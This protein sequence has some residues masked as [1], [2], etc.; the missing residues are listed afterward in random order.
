MARRAPWKSA[1]G[2]P[3]QPSGGSTP[4]TTAR[5]GSSAARRARISRRA[6]GRAVV[7]DDDFE[8]RIV[9]RRD[10]SARRPR[11]RRPR[12]RRNHDETRG[13]A[14]ARGDLR[15][16]TDAPE[17]EDI[18]REGG[19]SRWPPAR[20]TRPERRGLVP[21][22]LRQRN[23]LP[24][25]RPVRRVRIVGEQ[26]LVRRPRIRRRA[27]RL[28]DLGEREEQGILGRGRR[29]GLDRAL[30]PFDGIRGLPLGSEQLGGID[31]GGRGGLGFALAR[32]LLEGL[33]RLGRL[34]GS[35][36]RED[37]A[38]SA[39]RARRPVRGRLAEELVRFGLALGCGRE[40]LRGGRLLGLQRRRRARPAPRE[41]SWPAERAA[42]A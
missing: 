32:G 37:D 36:R 24:G 8:V 42:Q 41:R 1:C 39:P 33:D 14:P 4:E 11:S 17:C 13:R 34:L 22:R 15:C 31:L 20:P 23:F 27:A 21:Q 6:V 25:I 2:L 16:G 12:S 7:H 40:C 26:S 29:R 9:L 10:A 28:V 5:R 18:D 3:S 38:S 30:Q 35:V 19:G